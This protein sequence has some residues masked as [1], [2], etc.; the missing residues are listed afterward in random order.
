MDP[1]RL[2]R[3]LRLAAGL[4]IGGAVTKYVAEHRARGETTE[5]RAVIGTGLRLYLALG[6]VIALIGVA[7]SPLIPRWLG[8]P[9]DLVATATATTAAM[10]IGL[11]IAIPCTTA[12]AVLR[13][14]Q[15]YDVAASIS[16]VGSLSSAGLTLVALALGWGIVGIVVVGDPDPG[17]HPGIGLRGGPSPRPG[18]D[19][20]TAP[21]RARHGPTDLRF[22]VA[23]V[24]AR[25][26]RTAAGE[27]G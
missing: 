22:L 6:A 2:D 10:S 5:T 25:R 21:D 18:P 9:P 13:G 12:T 7:L 4:G 14:L 27:V 1:H 20:G 17:H 16:I 24:P 11:G 23:A 19:H 26:R 8:V 3:R 15:R